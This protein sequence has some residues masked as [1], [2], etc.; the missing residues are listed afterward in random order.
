MKLSNIRNIGR[1]KHWNSPWGVNIKTGRWA[2]RGTDNLFYLYR[3]QRIF[4]SD[5]AFY[6]EWEKCE[7]E[8]IQST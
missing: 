8:H 1:Y 2:A 7:K 3:G 4:I 5:R 6:S